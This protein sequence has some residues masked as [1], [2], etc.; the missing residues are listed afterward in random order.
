MT[1]WLYSAIKGH[2]E[3]LLWKNFGVSYIQYT[4]NV[5][6]AIHKDFVK[7]SYIP[8]FPTS[9]KYNAFMH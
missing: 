3:L 2:P 8:G 7:H 6:L 1:F 9:H 5:C 4:F